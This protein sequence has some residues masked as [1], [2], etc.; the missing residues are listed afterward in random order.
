MLPNGGRRAFDTKKNVTK[1]GQEIRKINEYSFSLVTKRESERGGTCR[2]A[3][4]KE[5]AGEE[6]LRE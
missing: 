2:D 1:T 4:R 6:G 3:D 5:K